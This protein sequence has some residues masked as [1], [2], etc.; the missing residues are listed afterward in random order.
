MHE[1]LFPDQ[2]WDE[3]A[4]YSN[5]YNENNNAP[6]PY[7]QPASNLLLSGNQRLWKRMTFRGIANKSLRQLGQLHSTVTETRSIPG[8]GIRVHKDNSQCQM[9]VLGLNLMNLLFWV[10]WD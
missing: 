1:T 4:S 10:C 7:P 2:P 6:P 5:F 8:R 9:V 3:T